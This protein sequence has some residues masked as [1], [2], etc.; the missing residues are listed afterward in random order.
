MLQQRTKTV[1]KPLHLSHLSPLSLS[2]GAWTSK[3][4]K[5]ASKMK[6]SVPIH[7]KLRAVLTAVLVPGWV[8]KHVYSMYTLVCWIMIN[9]YILGV[10]ID[11]PVYYGFL[12]MRHLRFL[13]LHFWPKVWHP[14]R[15]CRFGRSWEFW[16]TGIRKQRSLGSWFFSTPLLGAPCFPTC[17]T[18]ILLTSLRLFH[19]TDDMVWPS[20]I[21]ISHRYL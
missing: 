13:S 1:E 20:H 8:E 10:S 6:H 3:G 21:A 12:R 2:R 18:E 7:T 4:E 17:A 5:F 11:K 16:E 14:L 9:I 19:K 15:S